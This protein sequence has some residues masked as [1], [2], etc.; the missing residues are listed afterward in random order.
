[1]TKH[2]PPSLRKP[3]MYGLEFLE[4]SV[5]K[6]FTKNFYLKDFPT[7]QLT[8]L[9][10][11]IWFRIFSYIEP[12]DIKKFRLAVSKRHRLMSR[13]FGHDGGQHTDGVQTHIISLLYNAESPPREFHSRRAGLIASGN[14]HFHQIDVSLND[15]KEEVKY[16]GVVRQMKALREM[17]DKKYL[18]EHDK[19]KSEQSTA[20]NK[21][22]IIF[23][24]AFA[25]CAT[26]I[27]EQLEIYPCIYKIIS[28][29]RHRIEI[30]NSH[31]K[32]PWVLSKSR[33]SGKNSSLGLFELSG[34]PM[35]LEQPSYNPIKL[36]GLDVC[37]SVASPS[38]VV[39][40]K[41][42]DG[43]PSFIRTCTFF[44][45]IGPELRRDILEENSCLVDISI[46]VYLSKTIKKQFDLILSSAR[47]KEPNLVRFEEVHF[48]KMV[49]GVILDY[50]DV[51]K[52][53]CQLL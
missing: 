46:V 13:L 19:G 29:I 21:V 51:L 45:G 39:R 3:S 16:Q 17:L 20:Y 7:K 1:M 50:K 34:F 23:E 44:Q 14:C 18:H 8:D 31:D 2:I 52:E 48:H 26:S 25:M 32:D 37:L 4:P 41:Q 42:S 22:F 28:P 5:M 6:Y 9:P 36:R 33:T 11:K 40:S 10:P 15:L 27:Y 43:V 35:I 49:Q 24:I 38:L 12:S 53:L 47:D 30:I